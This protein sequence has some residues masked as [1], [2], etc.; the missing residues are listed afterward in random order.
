MD[1]NSR[2]TILVDSVYSVPVLVENKSFS[3]GC[4]YSLLNSILD[5]YL[6]P[7]LLFEEKLEFVQCLYIDEKEHNI[8]G[9]GVLIFA[10][11]GSGV[12]S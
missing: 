11:H 6:V 10:I 12:G 3:T 4:R 2:S 5:L 9:T 1:P 7:M 8:P